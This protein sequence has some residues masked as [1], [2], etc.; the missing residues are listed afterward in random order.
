MGLFIPN[1]HGLKH[2]ILSPSQVNFINVVGEPVPKTELVMAD[3]GDKDEPG[4]AFSGA[5][6]TRAFEPLVG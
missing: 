6:K 1:A 4:T 3:P 5:I 2:A